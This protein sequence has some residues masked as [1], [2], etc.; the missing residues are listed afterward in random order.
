MAASHFCGSSQPCT[1][2]YST[3][4]TILSSP[5]H[6]TNIAH[7]RPHTA[8]V[9]SQ[10]YLEEKRQPSQQKQ[11]VFRP[12]SKHKESRNDRKYQRW[13][14]S[15]MFKVRGGK[16]R[17]WSIG[18]SAS[19]A[20]FG[21]VKRVLRRL[22]AVPVN[23]WTINSEFSGKA[24]CYCSQYTCYDVC[25]LHDI[26]FCQLQE[27]ILHGHAYYIIDLVGCPTHPDGCPTRPNDFFVKVS[28][29]IKENVQLDIISHRHFLVYR[30]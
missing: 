1:S 9:T 7:T 22:N 17:P 11:S 28:E 18:F 21:R 19:S 6:T 5:K 4:R 14:I 12:K 8:C 24:Y 26:L 3:M 25:L 23:L 16:R 30:H 2:G 15:V 10:N 29:T 13:P 27:H 20:I